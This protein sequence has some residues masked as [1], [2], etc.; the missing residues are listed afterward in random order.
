MHI[1]MW[2]EIGHIG[3]HSSSR[4]NFQVSLDFADYHHLYLQKKNHSGV[5]VQGTKKGAHF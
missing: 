5:C 4:Q 1:M 3:D 2:K